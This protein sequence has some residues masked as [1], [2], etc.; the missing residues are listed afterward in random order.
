MN[1][2]SE[3]YPGAG[4]ASDHSLLLGSFLAPAAP[5]PSSG[6]MHADTHLFTHCPT[7]KV[8]S[9]ICPVLFYAVHSPPCLSLKVSWNVTS[10][11]KSVPIQPPGALSTNPTVRGILPYCNCPFLLSEHNLQKLSLTFLL[12]QGPAHCLAHGGCPQH[13]VHKEM[14]PLLLLGKKVLPHHCHGDF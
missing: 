4:S 2:R 5:S 13:L 7:R 9:H 14:L 11:V 3:S 1:S 12:F 10:S 8:P 6:E